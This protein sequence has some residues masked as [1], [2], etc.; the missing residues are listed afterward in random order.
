MKWTFFFCKNVQV[1]CRTV[2][3]KTVTLQTG[4]FRRRTPAIP[5]SSSSSSCLRPK[6]ESCTALGQLSCRVHKRDSSPQ[7]TTCKLTASSTVWQPCSLSAS[8]EQKNLCYYYCFMCA[9]TA[10]N[11]DEGGGEFQHMMPF[12]NLCLE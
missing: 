6:T 1:N 8:W 9:H 12:D 7:M 2:V 5:S 4:I 3:S 11:N 10:R